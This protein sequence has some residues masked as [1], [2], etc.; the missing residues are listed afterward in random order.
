[1][2]EWGRAGGGWVGWVGVPLLRM[3]VH[4]AYRHAVHLHEKELKML[5]SS[6][7]TIVTEMV[8]N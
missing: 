5:S 2:F 3:S 1:M 4:T 8:F 7:Y 6:V